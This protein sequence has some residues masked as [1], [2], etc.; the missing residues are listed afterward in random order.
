MWGV[1]QH[2]KFEYGTPQALVDESVSSESANGKFTVVSGYWEAPSGVNITPTGAKKQSEVNNPYL[3]KAEY[4]DTPEAR[5]LG[6]TASSAD[7]VYTKQLEKAILRASSWINTY[8]RRYFDTQ[9]IDEVVTGFTVKPFNPRL[10]SVYTRNSPI[11][12][13]NSIYIQVLKFFIQIESNPSTSYIQVLPD[14]GIFKIV[15]LLSSAGSGANVPVPAAILDKV[16]LGNLWYNYSFGF[17]QPIVGYTLDTIDTEISVYRF[18]ATDYDFQLWAP[19]QTVNVYIDGVL[20]LSSTYTIDYP[21]GIVSFKNTMS[22]LHTITVDFTTNNS[23]PSAIK[24]ACILLTTKYLSG[25]QNPL[26]FSSLSVP[27]YS[28]SYGKKDDFDTEI[29]D[30]LKAFRKS[31]IVII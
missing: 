3:S 12:N 1:G 20:Q 24:T 31:S 10:V 18:Q 29:E 25:L 28:V 17:G 23:I 8:C 27:G 5:G 4:I 15:P 19:S 2:G 7:G 26:K 13:I 21:N 6:I 16:P 9:T 30:L 22:P 11:Q 14:I